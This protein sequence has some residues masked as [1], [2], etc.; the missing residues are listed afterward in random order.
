M[1]DN[2]TR[3]ITRKLSIVLSKPFRY[4]GRASNMAWLGF[5]QDVSGEDFHGKKR[6]LAQYALHVQCSFRVV[7]LNK[8]ILGNSDIFEPNTQTKCMENF[9]WDVMGGNL[10][11]EKSQILIEE[12]K[13]ESIV[14]SNVEVSCWGDLKLEL[15][16]GYVIE[17][18]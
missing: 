3:E 1:L 8:I 17:I 10:Y 16:D 18:L 5:G 11:D 9:N 4:I 14:V 13:N 12:L 6:I 2:E 15:T 7:H